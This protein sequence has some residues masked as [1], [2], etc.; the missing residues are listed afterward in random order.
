MQCVR[1]NA[2]LGV[3]PLNH[4]SIEPDKVCFLRTHCYFLW[5]LGADL[6]CCLLLD[7]DTGDIHKFA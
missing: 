7:L 3:F 2:N 4:L 1:H 5:R 6:L